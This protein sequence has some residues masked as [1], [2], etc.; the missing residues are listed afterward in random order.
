MVTNGLVLKQGNTLIGPQKLGNRDLW[1]GP[2]CPFKAHYILLQAIFAIAKLNHF[3][4][5]EQCTVALNW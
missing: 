3:K 4:Q 2:K 5:C 1:L